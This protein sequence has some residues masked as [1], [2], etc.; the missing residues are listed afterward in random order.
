MRY[1]Y[2]HVLDTLKNTGCMGYNAI[3]S[4]QPKLVY[5]Q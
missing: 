5:F 2:V 3:E 4:Y 1:I